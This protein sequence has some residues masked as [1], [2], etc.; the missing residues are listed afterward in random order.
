MANLPTRLKEALDSNGMTAAELS[1]RTGISEGGISQYLKGTIYPRQDK[2]I[3]LSEALNVTPGWLCAY[4]DP[5]DQLLS[6]E[7]AAIFRILPEDLQEQA[8]TFMHFLNREA[9]RR[10][11]QKDVQD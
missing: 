3:I 9:K 4:D 5:D 1:R 10:E 8:L 6:M 2:I 11:E 7:V